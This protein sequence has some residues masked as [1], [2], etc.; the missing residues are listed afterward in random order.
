LVNADAGGLTLL[1]IF[2]GTL[3][4]LAIVILVARCAG[5]A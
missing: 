5:P 1:D 4:V 2:L 3:A